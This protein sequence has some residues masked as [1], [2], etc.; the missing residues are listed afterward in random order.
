MGWAGEGVKSPFPYYI[1]LLLVETLILKHI[2]KFMTNYKN[3][4]A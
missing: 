4:L 1:Y 2:I 3:I